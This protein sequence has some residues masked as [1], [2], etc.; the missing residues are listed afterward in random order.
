MINSL[1]V[2]FKMRNPL[3]DRGGFIGKREREREG[4]VIEIKWIDSC[5]KDERLMKIK[6]TLIDI[7]RKDMA[8][9]KI[10]EKKI[11]VRISN[12]SQKI[13]N[14]FFFFEKQTHTKKHT[15]RKGK[16]F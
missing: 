7:I 12:Q 3:K 15:Q 9:N 14:F 1:K 16:G 6:I 11:H 5:W 4:I 13:F 8:I 10:I 2:R